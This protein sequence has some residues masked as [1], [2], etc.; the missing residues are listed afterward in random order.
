MPRR[1]QSYKYLEEEGGALKQHEQQVQRAWG[2]SE[3]A[4]FFPEQKHG[5]LERR[6]Y[7]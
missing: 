6:E 4:L 7:R 5:G 3:L 2:D 1:I